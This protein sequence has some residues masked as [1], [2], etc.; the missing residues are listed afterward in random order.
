MR[1]R[2]LL[3]VVRLPQTRRCAHDVIR[4]R[5]AVVGVSVFEGGQ[6]SERLVALVALLERA[7][8]LIGM[9]IH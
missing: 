7:H 2:T 8:E 9:T 6:T 5:L 1:D 4:A 3:L